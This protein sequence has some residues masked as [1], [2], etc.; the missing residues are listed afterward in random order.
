[1]RSTRTFLSALALALAPLPSWSADGLDLPAAWEADPA[2]IFEATDISLD[3]LQWVARPL[4]VFANSP[5]DPAFI[6]QIADLERDI[7]RLVERDVIVIVDTDRDSASDLRAKLRPRGFML[8][9]IGKD[10]QVKLRKP[11]PLTVREVSR[12]IDK[13]PIRQREIRDGS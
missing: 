3:D 8:V 5:R 12:S 1:M 10:G 11:L 2:K 7:D 4:I 13:M 6:E 9:L